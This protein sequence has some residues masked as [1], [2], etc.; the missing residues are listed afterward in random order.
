LSQSAER[1]N[2]RPRE[3]QGEQGE[4]TFT[5]R[6]EEGR[7]FLGCTKKDAGNWGWKKLMRAKGGKIGKKFLAKRS[8]FCAALSIKGRGFWGEG[9]KSHP[10]L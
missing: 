8:Y 10:T 9:R 7:V 4:G 6:T 2:A 1:E 5:L 3:G